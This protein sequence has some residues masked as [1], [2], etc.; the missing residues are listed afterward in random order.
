M[1]DLEIFANRLQ[2]FKAIH[3]R[4][5]LIG[6]YDIRMIQVHFLQTFYSVIGNVDIELVFQL[7]L[8]Q[9]TKVFVV[10]HQQKSWQ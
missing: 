9:L 10:F 6:Y 5:H 3:F 8:Y 1:A 4:H 7:K 2:H